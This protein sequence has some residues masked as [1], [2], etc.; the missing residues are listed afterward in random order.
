MCF[1][2]LNFILNWLLTIVANCVK[3]G[4]KVQII[5]VKKMIKIHRNERAQKQINR[6]KILNF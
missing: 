2:N 5:R 1:F 6:W 3:T 4:W